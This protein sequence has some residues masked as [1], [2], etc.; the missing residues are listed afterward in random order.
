MRR[1]FGVFGLSLLL[2][3]VAVGQEL[4]FQ[5][6]V[7]SG[8]GR[9]AEDGPVVRAQLGSP[10][11]VAIDSAGNTYVS[12]A[13]NQTIRRITLAGI[14]T[15]LAGL[16]GVKGSADG[17][18][19]TAQF[20]EPRGV[21]V[22]GAGNVYVADSG[23]HTIRKVS[24]AG[25]V[26]TLAGGVGQPG[27]A[28]GTG[29][30]A[31]F[32]SP[33]GLLMEGDGSVLVADEEN[34]RI[35][36]VSG[37]GVVTTLTVSGGALADFIWP[38]GVAMDAAGNI[39]VAGGFT[40]AKLTPTGVLTTL[41]GMPWNPGNEDGT[42]ADARF[43]FPTGIASDAAGNLWVT[44]WGTI[45]SVS[46]EGV[47]TTIAG[48]PVFSG[49]QDGTGSAARFNSAS[50]IMHT[51]DG[52]LLVADYGNSG[53]RRVTPAGVVTT[54]AGGTRRL[55]STDGVGGI[56]RFND[57]WGVAFDSSGYAYVAD[58]GNSTIRKVSP[59]GLVTTFAGLAGAWG[60]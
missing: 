10:W 11:G 26:T 48:D 50:A 23:N 25:V 12:D 40:I 34:G 16:A 58:R 20:S 27:F 31:R 3:S 15:T 5:H 13:G 35:R 19:S 32:R 37:A 55:G 52:N 6:F 59:E 30:A 57:P 28:D 1:T 8:G 56:A 49:D 18:G 39:Y 14:V 43:N 9:G 38:A 45:R 4:T 47:V 41:A 44:E 2:A 42:G 60:E 46:P 21:A 53:L 51:V 33:A 36:R 17:R 54:F 29:D 22:D 24:P 7:G